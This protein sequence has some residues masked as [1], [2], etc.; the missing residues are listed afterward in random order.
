MA[1][2]IART[3][4]IVRRLD[5][6]GVTTAAFL[7][8]EPGQR[9][10]PDAPEL[11]GDRS[12]ARAPPAS[13]SICT[14]PLP[15]VTRPHAVRAALAERL[16]HHR[17]GRRRRNPQRGGQRLLR[18]DGG[19]DRRRRDARRCSRAGPVATSGGRRHPCRARRGSAT[20][21]V[22]IRAAHRRRPR[23]FRRRAAPIL[24]QHRR[25]RHGR[26]GGRARQPERSQGAAAFAAVRCSWATSLVDAAG[27]TSREWRAS[28]STGHGSSATCAA[29]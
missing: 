5:A 8:H 7:V 14:A 11:A 21:R 25:L 22:R 6:P 20:D 23:R 26:R 28:R 16:S 9:R 10:G 1:R 13:P 29:S 15:R 17:R 19:R 3:R 4:E 27:L 24:H 2:D 12:G 18:P